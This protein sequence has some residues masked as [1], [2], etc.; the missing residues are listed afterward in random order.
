MTE[1]LDTMRPRANHR[2]KLSP[3]LVVEFVPANIDARGNYA[4]IIDAQTPERWCARFRCDDESRAQF[5]TRVI[6]EA[7]HATATSIIFGF[8]PPIPE[9]PTP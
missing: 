7:R 5:H 9:E 2:I 8:L 3:H 4:T 1:C 6:E